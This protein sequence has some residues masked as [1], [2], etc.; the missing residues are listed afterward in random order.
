MSGP[1]EHQIQCALIQWFDN[2]HRQ[3]RGRLFAIPNGGL[4]DTRVAK[5]MKAEGVRR[6]VPDLFLPVPAGDHHGLFIELKRPGGRLSADQKKWLDFLS[7]Q[8]YRAVCCTGFDEA[9]AEIDA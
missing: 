8:G 9:A 1:S 7:G 2:T 4:R 6:G 3:H 5:K